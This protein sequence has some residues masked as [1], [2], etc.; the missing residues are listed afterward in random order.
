MILIKLFDYF[1]RYEKFELLTLI[2]TK[3][4]FK[5]GYFKLK[6]FGRIKYS[7]PNKEDFLEINNSL[8]NESI[9]IESLN[10][11]YS[12]FQDFIESGF[13]DNENNKYKSN[14]PVFLE[15]VFEHW[16]SYKLLNLKD[17][18]NDDIYLDIAGASSPWSEILRSKLDIKAFTI[19]LIKPAKVFRKYSFYIK[20]DATKTKFG[21]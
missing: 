7:A 14:H 13:F 15:K 6:H 20:G 2:I 3:L 9:T 4:K 17:L 12:E 1:D 8:R 19:D 21:H 11:K 10:F 18:N 16:L 5:I